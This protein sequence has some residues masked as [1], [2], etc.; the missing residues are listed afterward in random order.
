MQGNLKNKVSNTLP[1]LLI[2]VCFMHLG[3][4]LGM[5]IQATLIDLPAKQEKVINTFVTVESI[6]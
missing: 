5:G 1:E 3:R 4:I 2:T 6:K